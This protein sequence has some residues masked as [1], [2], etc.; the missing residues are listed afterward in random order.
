MLCWRYVC[1]Y[2][3]FVLFT[4]I[5]VHSFIMNVIIKVKLCIEAYTQKMYTCVKIKTQ[6]LKGT[7]NKRENAQKCVHFAYICVFH[8]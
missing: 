5:V 8:L 1:E 4:F 6:L 2:I 7:G 3:G